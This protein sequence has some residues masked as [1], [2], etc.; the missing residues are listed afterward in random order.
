MSCHATFPARQMSYTDQGTREK[1][2]DRPDQA[3]AAGQRGDVI[4]QDG[5]GAGNAVIPV[6]G[7]FI[8][9]AHLQVRM[10]GNRGIDEVDAPAKASRGAAT[11]PWVERP[12]FLSAINCPSV[13]KLI[14]QGRA[15]RQEV[16]QLRAAPHRG[17]AKHLFI[18]HNE[19]CIQI[20]KTGDDQTGG[21]RLSNQI[22]R[23]VDICLDFARNVGV[24]NPACCV[25]RLAAPGFYAPAVWPIYRPCLNRVARNRP[26]DAEWRDLR[27]LPAASSGIH[28]QRH[29]VPLRSA[30]RQPGS[31]P[32]ISGELAVARFFASDWPNASAAR[33]VQT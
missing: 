10:V 28:A 15:D 33:R 13:N 29:G 7:P 11:W 4:G 9:M 30:R 19:C 2:K 21:Q 6:A 31:R 17:G 16:E 22:K 18:G 27:R 8:E 32:E 3:P 25:A 26:A 20:T 23:A 5:Q 12:I 14:K 24:R 1:K